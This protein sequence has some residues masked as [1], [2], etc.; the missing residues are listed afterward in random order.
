MILLFYGYLKGL[1]RHL[2][3]NLLGNLK[4]EWNMPW[5]WIGDFNVVLSQEQKVGRDIVDLNQ[6]RQFNSA[7]VDCKLSDIGS[8]GYKMT[9]LIVCLHNF[10]Q[11]HETS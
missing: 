2:S 5:F 4:L 10:L 11:C 1:D 8:V 9:W 6:T 7:L 3:W